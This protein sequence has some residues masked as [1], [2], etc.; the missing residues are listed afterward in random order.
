VSRIYVRCPD[1]VRHFINRRIA[2][3][4]DWRCNECGARLPQKGDEQ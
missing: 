1:C 3:K 2:V 4:Y